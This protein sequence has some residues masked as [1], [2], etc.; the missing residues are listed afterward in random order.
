MAANPDDFDTSES[1]LMLARQLIHMVWGSGK[2]SA[3]FNVEYE[4]AQWEVSVRIKDTEDGRL[5]PSSVTDF[6][7]ELPE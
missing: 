4:G 7:E 6:T 2:I 3:I 5:P 1:K